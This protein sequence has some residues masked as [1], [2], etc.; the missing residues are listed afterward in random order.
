MSEQ[1]LAELAVR[2]REFPLNWTMAEMAL[3]VDQQTIYILSEQTS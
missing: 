2:L 1:A 3:M